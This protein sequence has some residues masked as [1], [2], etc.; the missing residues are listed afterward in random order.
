MSAIG[1]GVLPQLGDSQS[2]AVDY[3][4]SASQQR[5]CNRPSRPAAKGREGAVI[6]DNA[7]EDASVEESQRVTLPKCTGAGRA[8]ASRP[9]TTDRHRSGQSDA[10][11]DAGRTMSTDRTTWTRA[12]LR[13]VV[14]RTVRSVRSKRYFPSNTGASPQEKPHTIGFPPPADDSSPRRS[15]ACC[16]DRFLAQ[17]ARTWRCERSPGFNGSRGSFELPPVGASGPREAATDTACL[18]PAQARQFR[19]AGNGSLRAA[20][21]GGRFRESLPEKTALSRHRPDDRGRGERVGV[22]GRSRRK[23]DVAA[24]RPRGIGP[25][26]PAGSRGADRGA[27]GAAG[28]PYRRSQRAYRAGPGAHPARGNRRAHHR[29]RRRARCTRRQGRG[30]GSAGPPCTRGPAA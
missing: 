6:S 15:I 13:A 14:A 3:L 12:V 10:S 7:G 29:D 9:S 2:L 16:P 25:A 22:V 28:E 18:H 20:R 17:E 21:D 19:E 8:D 23:L 30:G 24:A 26:T 1:W 4:A 5:M 11:V 27:P